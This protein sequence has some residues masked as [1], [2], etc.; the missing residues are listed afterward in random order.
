MNLVKIVAA[1]SKLPDDPKKQLEFFQKHFDSIVEFARSTALELSNSARRV[2]DLEHELENINI[3]DRRIVTTVRAL[4]DVIH[5]V[6]IVNEV[7]YR[8]PGH[9]TVLSKYR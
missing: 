3:V 4:V 6:P 5:N 7:K 2:E 8:R 9:K 1:R